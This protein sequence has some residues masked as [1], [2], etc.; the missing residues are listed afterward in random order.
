MN[1]RETESA[2]AAIMPEVRRMLEE[3]DMHH[4][5]IDAGA[6]LTK[7]LQEV[8]FLNAYRLTVNVR[9]INEA[10][11][12]YVDTY[13]FP[14]DE[15]SGK[16]C[17]DAGGATIILG[18]EATEIPKG[19][20][21]GH[22]TVIVPSAFDTKHALLDPAITQANWPEFGIVLPPLCLKVT[23][24]F[25]SGGRS[26]SFEVNNTLLIYDAYPND[27]SYNDDGDCMAKEHFDIAVSIVLKR[28]E[29]H[30]K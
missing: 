26:A 2:L 8:G 9:I 11:R 23:D 13:G 12:Q 28:L 1:S 4:S 16:A 6:L 30:W 24:D 14:S 15:A 18:K 17:D 7:V 29:R 27:R 3:H 10:F 21:P 5:C 20:W 22:L 25:V 19:N